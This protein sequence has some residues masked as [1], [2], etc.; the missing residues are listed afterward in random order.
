MSLKKIFS[1]DVVEVW[2]MAIF[3]VS[4]TATGMGCGRN[5][6]TSLLNATYVGRAMTT[7]NTEYGSTLIGWSSPA[8]GS[9]EHFVIFLCSGSAQ[10]TSSQDRIDVQCSGQGLDYSCIV[11][12]QIKDQLNG[13]HSPEVHLTTKLDG[14]SSGIQIGSDQKYYFVNVVGIGVN[15]AG[16]GTA[17]SADKHFD[18]YLL[19]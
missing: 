11:N 3:A 13:A 17:L 4:I 14:S 15:S 2:F 1:F 10:C 5:T 16:I 19:K 12:D 18:V 6:S 7:N 8:S 9:N